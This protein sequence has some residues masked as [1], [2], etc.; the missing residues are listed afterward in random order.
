M[1]A[2]DARI[3]VATKTV[4]FRGSFDRLGGIVR[5]RLQ[6]D[7]RSGAFF[8]F[9]NRAGTESRSCSQIRPMIA[10]STNCRSPKSSSGRLSPCVAMVAATDTRQRYDLGIIARSRM[11]VSRAQR[12]LVQSDV[13]PVPMIIFNVCMNAGAHRDVLPERCHVVRQVAPY[14]PDPSL[15]KPVLPW[16]SDGS[17]RRLRTERLDQ[18]VDARGELG[19]VVVEK[20]LRDPIE[21]EC[22]AQLL[23]DSIPRCVE[24][25]DS[26]PW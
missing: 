10:C 20:L 15:A 22:I 4:D 12:A 13:R 9:F 11:N 19:V 26:L 18:P 3:F 5:E 2:V 16:A 24:M 7:P 8:V 23:C 6:D 1:I 17:P 21:W 25:E 14:G